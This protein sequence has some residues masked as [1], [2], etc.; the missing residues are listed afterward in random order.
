[1]T[2]PVE[3]PAAQ[4]KAAPA[5]GAQSE[6][7]SASLRYRT[8]DPDQILDTLRVLR[9][10][11]G[12]RFPGSGLFKVCGELV[13]HGE[14]AR[15]RADE[16]GRPLVWLRLVSAVLVGSIVLASIAVFGI[17]QM[18]RESMDAAQLVTTLEAAIND[19]VL[20]GAA[21]FFLVTLEIR[22]KRKKALSALRELR[23][24]AHIIDMHQL[25]KDPERL[26]RRGPDTESSPK[27]GMGAFELGRYLDYCSEMLSLTGKLAALYVEHFDDSVTL[28]SANELE[29]LCTGLSRKI[30]QKIMI[31]QSVLPDTGGQ[32][33]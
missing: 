7:S 32:T 21:I 6:P 23:S 13:L 20:V 3:P 2:N 11:I 22:I 30:W 16:I 15:E 17:V 9:R 19:I 18:P 27:E 4:G 5:Q 29:G 28:A 24:V 10:R 31:V 25:T 1:M 14:Q 33:G 26:I 8:L 12:E